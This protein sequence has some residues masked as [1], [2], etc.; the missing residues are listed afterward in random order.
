M[1]NRKNNL[2][3]SI[4]KLGIV[5]IVVAILGLVVIGRIIDLQFI[6]KP[7]KNRF[8][9]NFRYDV[10]DGKRGDILA[11]DGRF[12]AVSTPQ[13]EIDMDCTVSDKDTFDRDVGKLAADLST[14]FNDKTPRYFESEMVNAREKDRKHIRIGDRL[15]S[16]QELQQ[17]QNFPIFNQGRFKGGLK[18]DKKE[19][20]LYPYTTLGRRVLGY[21]L[22]NAEKT[23]VGL[24]MC[25]DY[26]LKGKSGKRPMMR[27]ENHQWIR[28]FTQPEIPPED[29]LDVLTTIDV[30]IQDIADRAL[31]EQLAK[32]DQLQ[33]GCVIVMETATGAIRAMVNLQKYEGDFSERINF[34]INRKGEPGSVF[35]LA[36][37]ISLIE[38]K[39]LKL[40][41]TIKAQPHWIYGGH[42]FEDHY[43]N[44][45]STISV[46]RGFEIS[47]NNVFRILAT[48]NY[49]KD[50]E[51]FIGKLNDLKIN[52]NFDF[53]LAGMEKAY[54]K[55]P[56]DPT[57]SPVDLPQIAMGYTV[58]LTPLHTLNFYNAV[59][60]GGKMMKPYLVSAF[61]KDGHPVK[62]FKP[63]TISVICQKSTIDTVKRALRGVVT[64]GTGRFTFKGCKVHVS[65]KT[66]TAQIV[67]PET[68]EY[69]DRN[70]YRQHQATFVGFFPSEAP[71]YSMIVVVYSEKTRSNFYGASWG[72]P[73][74]RRVAEQIYASSPEWQK[75]YYEKPGDVDYLTSLK[76]KAPEDTAA[77]GVPCVVG[78]GL[79]DAMYILENRGFKVNFSGNGKVIAQ[80]PP[81]G[82]QGYRESSPR[83]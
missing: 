41:Q 8:G 81:A 80:D 33:G 42:D 21:S 7:D 11:R 74:F 45:Y 34:A 38:Q 24:E 2:K 23:K 6:H 1:R 12:L 59:A 77:A 63:E 67:D 20:R 25:Y 44:S 39:G 10:I 56:E 68:G 35:K 73:V 62:E 26:V 47:S 15:V 46:L 50:P 9:N 61:L 72:G 65:G 40:D 17:I 60:N 75:A 43:L 27:T 4:T 36:T 53:D 22:D 78:M 37:L 16:H 3:V 54:I 79:K 69:V 55:S 28:D 64:D 76:D 30:D 48:T 31:R 52:Y 49:E 83:R 32:S 13:Y 71:K 57:W 82:A 58:E 29:G 14:I 18:V 19:R 70:G 51:D 5:Y 66:G